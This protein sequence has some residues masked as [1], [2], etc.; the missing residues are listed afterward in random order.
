VSADLLALLD[1]DPAAGIL[2]VADLREQ[3]AKAATPGPYVASRYLR[4]GRPDGGDI[5]TPDDG[6]RPIPYATTWPDA[7]RIAALLNADLA[8]VRRWREVVERH[9]P[10][11]ETPTSGQTCASCAPKVSLDRGEIVYQQP[12]WPCPD[13]TETADEARAYLGGAA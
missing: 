5:V 8:A 3:R 12:A 1:R 11:R 7:E 9:R 2:A 6:P 13:L 4:P 10:D